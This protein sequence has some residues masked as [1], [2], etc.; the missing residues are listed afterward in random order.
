[1][2]MISAICFNII[3]LLYKPGKGIGE[4]LY[5]GVFPPKK[6]AKYQHNDCD[7]YLTSCVISSKVSYNM[8]VLAVEYNSHYD[9]TYWSNF[10]SKS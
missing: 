7:Q 2:H 4:T 6:F 10:Q 3:A 1:M 8:P 5:T 9:I